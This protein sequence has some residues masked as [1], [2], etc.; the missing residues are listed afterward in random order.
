MLIK[1]NVAQRAFVLFEVFDVA[2]ADL[3]LASDQRIG[4]RRKRFDKVGLLFGERLDEIKPLV[5][6]KLLQ[7]PEE[8]GGLSMLSGVRNTY[9]ALP[10]GIDQVVKTTGAVCGFNGVRVVENAYGDQT[11]GGHLVVLVLE[12]LGKLLRRWR[13]VFG[14]GAFRLQCKV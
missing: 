7:I 2:E 14:Q 1:K 13:N 6:S 11:P 3:C 5:A 10:L 9:F 12:L 4:N 8:L